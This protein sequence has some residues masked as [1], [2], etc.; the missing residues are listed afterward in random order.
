MT[1]PNLTEHV[2]RKTERYAKR[3]F[4]RDLDTDTRY[5]Y[6]GFDQET[7]RMAGG[8]RKLEI[9]RGDRVALLHP[10]HTDFILAYMAIIKAGGVAVP[11]NTAYT[12]REVA[13][14]L[15]DSGSRMMITTAAFKSL[16]EGVRASCT[17]LERIIMKAEG[18]P[19]VRC[20]ERE[21]G[22]L[23]PDLSE[24]GTA[25]DLAFIFYTSGTT[26]SPKGVMLTHR[27]LVFGGGNTAQNYG[28]RE[29]DVTLACLPLVHIFA[30][31]SPVFGSLNSGGCVIVLERFQTEQVMEAMELEGVTWF[32]GVPT[33]FGYLLNAF[34][35]RP[36]KT[37]ALRMALS[38]GASLSAEHLTRFESRFQAPV[39]E[40]YGLTESTGLVTANPVYGIRKVGAIGVN[41]SG[42]STRLVDKDSNEVPAGEVG[43]LI[44]RGPNATPGYWN[45]PETTAAAIKDGWVR[46]GDLARQD[47][48]GY[49]FIVGRKDEM[50]ISGGYNI[51]PRE[52]EEVLY[53]H[54]EISEAAVVGL[55]DQNLGDVPKAFVSLKEGSRLTPDAIVDFCRLHLAAY[56]VPRQVEIIA[57]LP[58]N[59][60]G[61]I[62][63]KELAKKSA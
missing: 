62:L 25:D 38:G 29:T 4:L 53:L 22:A 44:F 34:D 24:G 20:L 37:P 3:L 6:A 10:N 16:L 1:T 49:F 2:K 59:T 23:K 50:L 12:G 18:E 26:G 5:T 46:T 61:K 17:S 15:N 39:L 55:K 47:E 13:Y 56:K 60:T 35:E 7:D 28:L 30:N 21:C 41:V 31:A 54:E 52:I 43:E 51:Y 8:L 33:M 48:D 63:K 27:N 11:V 40:V 9:R 57:A 36:R 45:R 42:V 32:P 14:I 19:L 58:K